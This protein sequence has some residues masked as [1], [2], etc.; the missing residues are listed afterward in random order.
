[1]IFSFA[2]IKIWISIKLSFIVEQTLNIVQVSKLLIY[3]KV[4]V[5][6]DRCL[7]PGSILCCVL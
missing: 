7:L 1:V 3:I 4:Q 5:N 2:I 6:S